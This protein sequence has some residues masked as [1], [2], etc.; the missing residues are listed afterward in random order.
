MPY[1]WRLIPR[2]QVLHQFVLVSYCFCLSLL[3]L[4]YSCGGKGG[5]A[6]VALRTNLILELPLQRSAEPVTFVHVHVRTRM[7]T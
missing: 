2:C 4:H 1:I 3:Q 7:H 6:V 5:G